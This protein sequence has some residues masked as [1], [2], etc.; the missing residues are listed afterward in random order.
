MTIN[1]IIYINKYIIYNN[2]SIIICYNSIHFKGKQ[3]EGI[4][5]FSL[6]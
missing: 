2:N 1:Y 4:L 6:Q 3:G 5:S